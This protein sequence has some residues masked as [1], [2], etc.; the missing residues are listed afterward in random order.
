MFSDVFTQFYD[1]LAPWDLLE[2]KPVTLSGS[3]LRLLI[4][5]LPR[6]CSWLGERSAIKLCFWDLFSSLLNSPLRFL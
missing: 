4:K 2:E 3:C 6:W 1:C 5:S